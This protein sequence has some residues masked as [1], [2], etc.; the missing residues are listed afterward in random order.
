MRDLWMCGMTP[1]PAMVPLIKVSSSSSP[2]MA[3]CKCRG[4][5]RFTFKSL[6][7]FP[8]SS[9]TSAVKY[10]KI[11]AEYTAAVAPTLPLAAARDFKSRW[12]RPTGNCRITKTHNPNALSIRRQN[13]MILVE[14]ITLSPSGLLGHDILISHRL[15]YSIGNWGKQHVWISWINVFQASLDIQGNNLSYRLVLWT[16]S[17]RGWEERTASLQLC[18]TKTSHATVHTHPYAHECFYALQPESYNAGKKPTAL[19]CKLETLSWRK[20]EMTKT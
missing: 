20:G 13:L 4:V 18:H 3:S 2:R 14:Y 12:I 7:A 10:S 6:L 8:A 5:I 17:I 16:A 15:V 11:A 19:E 1:P 9:S